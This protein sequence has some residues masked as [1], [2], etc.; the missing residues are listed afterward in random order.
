VNTREGDFTE[1]M[2]RVPIT[3]TETIELK[4]SPS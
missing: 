3:S 4:K 1:L 2:I